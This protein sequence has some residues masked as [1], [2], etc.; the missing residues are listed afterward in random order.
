MLSYS[1]KLLSQVTAR[2]CLRLRHYG[3]HSIKYN[4]VRITQRL[5]FTPRQS[6]DMQNRDANLDNKDEN[7]DSSVQPVQDDVLRDP[8]LR[9][10]DRGSDVG[11]K[12]TEFNA[13]P[14]TEKL[15][16]L[17]QKYPYS[18]Q[19]NKE[20]RDEDPLQVMYS[21][22]AKDE[23]IY[24][25]DNPI[26]DDN[27]NVKS[28]SE[29]RSYYESSF[30]TIAGDSDVLTVSDKPRVT[31]K[32]Y[33]NQHI[34]EQ[35]RKRKE[36]FDAPRELPER[37]SDSQVFHKVNQE[38]NFN[39]VYV[40]DVEFK[41]PSKNFSKQHQQI[42]NQQENQRDDMNENERTVTSK[43]QN[44]SN[45]TKETKQDQNEDDQN[46]DDQ[47]ENDQNENDQNEYEQ[48]EDVGQLEDQR[49]TA[50]N[51]D[52]DLSTK[53]FQKKLDNY[54]QSMPRESSINVD[55]PYA[56]PNEENY[57]KDNNSEYNTYQTTNPPPKP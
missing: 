40:G 35:E 33:Q 12:S 39:N 26:N 49:I 36:Q 1:L 7:I 25:K 17:Y 42:R 18:N 4:F 37:D 14:Y 43:D 20:S 41:I 55:K 56:T 3:S 57:L 9:D 30:G 46:E 34:P 10:K 6:I 24:P 48:D 13:S 27:K 2:N 21:N 32:I 54:K 5:Y 38:E 50:S 8:I 44:Y 52:F 51:V 22:V 31:S 16:K 11:Q 45:A 47:N 28:S 53:N 23:D 19:S 29:T 15:K